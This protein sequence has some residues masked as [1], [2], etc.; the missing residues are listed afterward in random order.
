MSANKPLFAES[1]GAG[2]RDWNNLGSVTYE[3]IVCELCGK[4]WEKD[5]DSGH[6]IGRFLDRQLVMDCC[7]LL[8]DVVYGELGNEF[9]EVTLN[10]F[11]QNSTSTDF[12][13]L[14]RAMK[15]AL[16]TAQ[17]RTRVVGEQAATLKAAMPS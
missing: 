16:E 4:R 3:E 7:G 12:T 14:L 6:V 15:T 1:A 8:L 9:V 17:Q 2:E 13:W 11:A 5:E 10:E